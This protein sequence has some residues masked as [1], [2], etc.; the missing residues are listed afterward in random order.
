VNPTPTAIAAKPFS[1]A[2]C[3]GA[4]LLLLAPAIRA[5]EALSKKHAC[6][7]CHHLA[8]S[9]VGPSWSA[10]AAKYSEGGY[11]AE[12]MAAGIRAGG[13]GKWGRVPMPAQPQVTPADRLALANWILQGGKP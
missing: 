13:S 6:S 2:V 3:A 7:A 11:T 4:V 1:R 5:S 10:I 8:Q 12:Q 9:G